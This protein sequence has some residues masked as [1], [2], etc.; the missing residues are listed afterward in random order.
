MLLDNEQYALML[1][2]YTRLTDGLY[3]LKAWVMLIISNRAS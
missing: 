3:I 2:L 1:W